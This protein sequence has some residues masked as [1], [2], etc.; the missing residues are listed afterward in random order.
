[1]LGPLP[2]RDVLFGKNLALLPF[3][4]PMMVVAIALSQWFR[5]MRMDYLAAALIQTIP[6]YLVFCIG[7]N[8]LSILAPITLKPGSGMPAPHQGIRHLYHI[9]FMLLVSLLVGVT[10]IP[11][12]VEALLGLI[13]NRGLPA[14]LVLGLLQA[15]V[16]V[17]VYRAALDWQGELLQRREQQILEI[18]AARAE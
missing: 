4:L 9:L 7:A 17:W 13:G 3:A 1:V 14:Y 6:M 10:F 11:L 2:R 16:A 8:L 12:G 5:P 15:P 18:V